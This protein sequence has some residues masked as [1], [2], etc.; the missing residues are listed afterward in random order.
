MVDAYEAVDRLRGGLIPVPATPQLGVCDFCRNGAGE[1]YTRCYQCNKSRQLEPPNVLPITMEVLGSLIHDHLRNYKDSN[2]ELVRQWMGSRL[3]ALLALFLD[4]HRSCVG[5]WDLVTCVPSVK[6]VALEPIVRSVP[7]LAR[8]YRQVL[9]ERPGRPSHQPSVE[10]FAVTYPV[11]GKRVLL[12]DD[13]FT[14]GAALFSSTAAIR[15]EGGLVIGPVVI[16]RYVDPR[17]PPSEALL[18][19]L[20]NETWQDDRCARCHGARPEGR[21]I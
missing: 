15:Q 20:C 13:T 10:H 21:L 16:G 7:E 14:T 6:R 19:W 4:R 18:R 8:G 2:N 9:R 3:A 17:W 12:L 1:G 11:S 5:D